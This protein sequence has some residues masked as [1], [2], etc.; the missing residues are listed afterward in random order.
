MCVCITDLLCYGYYTLVLKTKNEKKNKRDNISI[1]KGCWGALWE[2][3]HKLTTQ[4]VHIMH[5]A[6]P[7][8][9]PSLLFFTDHQ[10]HSY[11][12]ES[13]YCCNTQTRAILQH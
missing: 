13:V 12:S 9:I 11:N 3:R 2:Q 1:P 7:T 10:L 8:A 6:C 4:S 5:L